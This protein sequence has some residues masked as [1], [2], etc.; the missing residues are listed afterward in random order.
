MRR[1]TLTPLSALALGA[2]LVLGGCGSQTSP[3]AAGSSAT[4]ATTDS[5]ASTPP[6]SSTDP[7][8]ATSPPTD[9]ATSTEAASSGAYLTLAEYQ[10]AMTQR[11]GTTVVYFFH[12][13]WCPSCRAT[14]ESLM[15]EG[16]PAG[17]TV[18][19]VDYDSETELRRE[20][21]ITQQHTFVHVD[22]GGTALA[23]WT[24]S[25]TGA[26]IAAETR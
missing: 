22:A 26:E 17:L 24:G 3:D 7:A 19:K 5:M 23:K 21:G 13:S 16:V 25:V 14:N 8:A 2:A 9:P 6:M 20:Y 1:T 10:D 12:A 4:S 15:T 11:E 18:V